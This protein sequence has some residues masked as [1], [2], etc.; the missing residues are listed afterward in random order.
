[1]Q[2]RLLTE[3]TVIVWDDVSTPGMQR[4]FG[5]NCIGLRRFHPAVLRDAAAGGLVAPR[6]DCFLSAVAPGWLASN[7]SNLIGI[8]G[9]ASVL[10]AIGLHLVLPSRLHLEDFGFAL[11]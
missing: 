3:Q 5:E 11:E 10:E 9:P 7:R 6:I 8:A 2:R 1:V 4:A